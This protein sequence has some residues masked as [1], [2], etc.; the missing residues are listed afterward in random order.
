MKRSTI[1]SSQNN[2][3]K[4]DIMKKIYPERRL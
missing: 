1:Y 2:I 4:M 3:G